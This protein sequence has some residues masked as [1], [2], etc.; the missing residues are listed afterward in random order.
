MEKA[1]TKKKLPKKPEE[2]LT[3]KGMAG[4]FFWKI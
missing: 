3:K 2:L 1:K 4:N